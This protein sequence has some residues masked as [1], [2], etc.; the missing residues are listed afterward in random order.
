M[1]GKVDRFACS[2]S[3]RRLHKI[4]T[5]N[6]TCRNIAPCSHLSSCAPVLPITWSR[7][8]SVLFR[9]SGG[10][11]KEATF[12]DAVEISRKLNLNKEYVWEIIKGMKYNTLNDLAIAVHKA[13]AL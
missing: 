6:Y 7:S 13:L 12:N 3:L 8:G 2:G 11:M 5:L 4:P 1:T 10:T 9:K